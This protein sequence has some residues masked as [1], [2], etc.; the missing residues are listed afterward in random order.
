MS[1]RKRQAGAPVVGIDLGGTN[2]TVGV[3][4]AK[5]RLLGRDR[6][7]TKA[8]QGRDAVIDRIV[9]SVGN[10]CRDAGTGL[11][12]IGAVG[13]GAPS[14]IDWDQGMVINA[15]NLGWRN[16][17][18]R[19]ILRKRFGV[20]VVV[21]N[22]VNVAAWGEHVL[23]AGRGHEDMLAVW[24]GTG[25]GAGLVLRGDVWRGPGFTA[26]EI[27]QMIL[28]PRS[29]VGRRTFEEHCSRT[30][31]VR[32]RSKEDG[33]VG[34]GAIA[35]AYVDGDELVQQVVDDAADLVGLAI[36]NAVTLLSLRCVVLGGGVTEAL[37]DRYVERVRESFEWH[38]FP[39]TLRKCAIVAS[40]LGDGAGVLGA[41]MLARTAM[42]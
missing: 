4:D 23:G 7:K 28:F 35:Q 5:G 39:A 29:S 34:S 11:E 17:P 21:D 42:E 33:P 14:A 13:I 25:I 19:E 31:M 37:G 1:D 20:P 38:V 12:D 26:G 22:D 3:V 2:F 27:G 30:A 18:L 16:V 36:A 6:R 9:E 40:E 32:E 41:A 10:A 24:I 8:H 15:G